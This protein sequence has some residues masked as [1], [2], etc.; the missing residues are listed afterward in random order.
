ML[1]TV[2][3]VQNAHSKLS[4]NDLLDYFSLG[5]SAKNILQVL[6]FA[7]SVIVISGTRVGFP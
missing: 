1:G 3:S 7:D 5:K 2:V 6:F 4:S